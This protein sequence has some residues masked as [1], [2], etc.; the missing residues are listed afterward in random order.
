M[1]IFELIDNFVNEYSK[2]HPIVAT[3]WGIHK[4]DDQWGEI[5]IQ[6]NQNAVAL[7]QRYLEKVKQ[8]HPLKTHHE[9]LAYYVFVDHLQMVID[10][11]NQ[12]SFYYDING[13]ASTFQGFADIFE[14]MPS[15]T[16]KDWENIIAR[17]QNMET[18]MNQYQQ[19]LQEALSLRKVVG[20]LQIITAIDQSN[21]LGY[22]FAQNLLKKATPAVVNVDYLKELIEH[23]RQLYQKFGQFLKNE[24]LPYA[25][26]DNAVGRENYINA[27]RSFIG[28]YINPEE[29][30]NWGMGILNDV[31]NE[32][33]QYTQQIDPGANNY[34]EVV[35]NAMKDP[36]LIMKDKEKFKDEVSELQ[37]NLMNDMQPYFKI[38][39]EIS[40]LSV[41]W[42][43]IPIIGERYMAPSYDFVTPG[44]IYY[45]FAEDSD[46]TLFD[47]LGVAY[48][49]GLPGHHLQ[50]TKKLLNTKLSLMERLSG[51]SGF[52]EGWAHYIEQFMDEI[53]Y[54]PNP[55]YRMGYLINALVRACRVLIDIGIH[56]K[57]PISDQL[58]QMIASKGIKWEASQTWDFESAYSM[59]VNV[60]GMN[61]DFANTEVV[62]Y[63]AMPGQAITYELGK[64]LL[65]QLRDRYLQKYPGDIYGF[66]EIILS[67]G[68]PGLNYLKYWFLTQ[69]T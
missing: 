61:E 34:M 45:R 9:Q 37:K 33:S 39:P 28:D 3:Y 27:A 41:E 63:Y 4:Y 2:L 19:L 11:I 51:Y 5:G 57:L 56:L 65:L 35:H 69:L 12:Q 50:L 1:N 58:R 20:R 67:Q 24:Y 60:A 18:A 48:H 62:R 40:N 47:Q 49:E 66:H 8:V 54:Y 14:R 23:N 13:Y 17:L 29:I 52:V 15:N 46:V 68:A 21:K 55:Y 31:L 30:Y 42:Y 16:P 7:G 22:T 38:P 43:P 25:A 59:L 32:I 6:S 64:Q 26:T 10:S 44:V 53:G 36:L